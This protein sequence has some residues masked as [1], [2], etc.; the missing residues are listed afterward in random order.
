MEIMEVLSRTADTPRKR[1][2]HQ[3][4][5]A[6]D[7]TSPMWVSKRSLEDIAMETNVYSLHV[8]GTEPV[9]SVLCRVREMLVALIWKSLTGAHPSQALFFL[10]AWVKHG[11]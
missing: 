10:T 8:P 3:T 11:E 5:H 6:I 2:S 7:E 9:I 1:P 4:T